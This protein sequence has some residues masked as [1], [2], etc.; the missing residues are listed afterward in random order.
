MGAIHMRH[1]SLK[2]FAFLGCLLPLINLPAFGEAEAQS[3]TR[4]MFRPDAL[5]VRGTAKPNPG[6][7]DFCKR[8]PAECR[9]ASDEPEVITLTKEVWEV[10]AK[11]TRQCR[12]Q[13][14]P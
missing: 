8:V 2:S 13:R 14:D 3:Y 4:S 5:E 9:H 12:S 7:L 11:Q 6:W 1:S 10:I